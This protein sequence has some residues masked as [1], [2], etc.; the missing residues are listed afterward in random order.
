MIP[1]PLKSP[2]ADCCVEPPSP[3]RARRGR[4]VTVISALPSPRSQV[5]QAFGYRAVRRI[6]SSC[7]LQPSDSCSSPSCRHSGAVRN[8]AHDAGGTTAAPQASTSPGSESSS[9][10]HAA[11]E[12]PAAAS[13]S[14]GS[15][16][17]TGLVRTEDNTRQICNLLC[18]KSQLSASMRVCKRAAG[19]QHA[20]R[21]NCAPAMQAVS[22]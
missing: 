8:L 15:R 14:A 1:S 3:S 2:P 6:R 13:T 22:F 21:A 7:S 12:S 17:C 18:K 9:G 4:Q 11:M 10:S 19:A 5:G 16:F 20:W